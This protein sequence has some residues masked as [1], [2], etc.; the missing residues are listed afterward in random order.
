MESRSSCSRSNLVFV[1][2]SVHNSASLF[3]VIVMKV[4]SFDQELG[5]SCSLLWNCSVLEFLVL[6]E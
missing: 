4:R 6:K 3:L 1:S 5:A 2:S